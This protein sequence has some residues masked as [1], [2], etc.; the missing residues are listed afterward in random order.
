M[1]KQA[2]I[3]QIDALVTDSA[4]PAGIKKLLEPRGIDVFV[5][6]TK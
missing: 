6:K 5:C 2:N 3:S 4:I 1:V